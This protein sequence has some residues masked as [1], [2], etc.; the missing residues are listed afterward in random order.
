MPGLLRG[1]FGASSLLSVSDLWQRRCVFTRVTSEHE[2]TIPPEALREA[3]LEPGDCVEVRVTGAGE[4]A[5]RRDTD[6]VKHV[7]GLFT[8][9]YEENELEALR[10]EWD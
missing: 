8:G 5:L 6:V 4:V 10:S 1:R 9:L 3:G 2:V 7:A